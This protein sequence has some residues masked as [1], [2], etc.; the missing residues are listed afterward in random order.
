MERQKRDDG[1]TLTPDYCTAFPRPG[2][3]IPLIMIFI[4]LEGKMYLITVASGTGE[5]RSMEARRIST[6][7]TVLLGTREVRYLM[8]YQFPYAV[9][10]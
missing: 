4:E 9:T 10:L 1:S 6:L 5:M 3:W 2:V 7:S 8:V